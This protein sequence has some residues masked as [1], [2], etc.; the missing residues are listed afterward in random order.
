[1]IKKLIVFVIIVLIGAWALQNYTSFK[2]LD[3]AKNYYQQV[4]LS[5][6]STWAE[7][8]NISNWFGGKK[9]PDPEKQLNVF[10]RDGIFLPNKSAVKKGIKI[11][12]YNEDIKAH[13]ITGE[14]WGSAEILAG[15]AFSKNFDLPGTFSYHCLI[16][17]SEKGEI[18]VGE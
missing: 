17:P 6:I 2:A 8:F 16:H 13:T 11:T 15:K 1:M 4:D 12:W 5:K 14:G 7:D 10:I 18:I 3:L 9:I